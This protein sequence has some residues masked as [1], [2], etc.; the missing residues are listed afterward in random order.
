M[1]RMKDTPM[2]ALGQSDKIIYYHADFQIAI[3]MN[4][5][6]DPHLSIDFITSNTCVNL[7]YF[8]FGWGGWD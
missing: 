1:I 4:R 8:F 7:R 5:H 2:V 6:C 3:E